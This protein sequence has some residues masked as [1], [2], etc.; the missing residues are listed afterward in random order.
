MN[1]VTRIVLIL[2]IL[3]VSSVT[4]R[5][6]LITEWNAVVFDILRAGNV[7]GA[8][9]ARILA[10]VHVSMADAVSGVS[11]SGGYSGRSG[12]SGLRGDARQSFREPS[13]YR[14]QLGFEDQAA[15]R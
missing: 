15:V 11:V 2:T 9:A 8:P 12:F 14:R 6:D 7:E 1:F 4:V 5:A 10:I 13:H 3:I